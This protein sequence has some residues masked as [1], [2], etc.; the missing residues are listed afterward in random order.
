MNKEKVFFV[1][2]FLIVGDIVYQ[3]TKYLYNNYYTSC[4]DRKK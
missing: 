2:T 1:L 3:G 4:K